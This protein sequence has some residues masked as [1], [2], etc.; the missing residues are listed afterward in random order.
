MSTCN[1]LGT[2]ARSLRG[3]LSILV[4]LALGLS[5]QM[6][7]AQAEGDEDAAADADATESAEATEGADAT[8]TPAASE[9]TA[10]EIPATYEEWLK[11]MMSEQHKPLQ[12]FGYFRSGFGVNSKLG[13]QEAFQA[14]GVP[15]YRLGNETET[16]GEIGLTNNWLNPDRDSDKAWFSTS[17]RV[18]FVTSNNQNYEPPLFFVP[19]AYALAGNVIKSKP[20]LKF[21]AGQRFYRREDIHINDYY[22]N[23][24][25]GYGGGVEDIDVGFAKLAIAYL[26]NSTDAE[27]T[28]NGR[29]TENNV[30]FRFY[31]IEAGPGSL[32]VAL[33][34]SFSRGQPD[35]ENV[36]GFS[37]RVNH[38][39]GLMGGFNRGVVE[40]GYGGSSDLDGPIFYRTPNTA[41]KDSMRLHVADYGQINLA[42]NITA[43]YAGIFRWK[44]NGDDTSDTW[45]SA[46]FRPIY[47][48]TKYTAVAAELGFDMTGGD[49]P[50]GTLTKFTVA[51]QIRA[52][53]GFWARPTIRA[54]VTA[55]F[56]TGDYEGAVGGAAF[57][58]DT[59]GMTMGV[60]AES[61]W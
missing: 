47:H 40:F 60:Q 32:G 49:A 43:M 61:W 3:Y 45:I 7:Q 50:S 41:L 42:D 9:E 51:P 27:V 36:P 55:A 56:W 34:G 46:G 1:V 38:T 25:S 11:K 19:E 13:D 15:K 52:G 4:L 28:E 5:T 30:E 14:P 17:I 44:D 29:I 24:E 58:A 20:D 31:G 53:D 2:K 35:F 12:F 16:Y 22:Y 10:A 59:F 18:A 48:F 54:F 23:S 39:M 37:L 33:K 57:A 8:E 21:W 6:A 26:G